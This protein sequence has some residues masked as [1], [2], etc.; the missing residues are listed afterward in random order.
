M[1]LIA[2]WSPS[3]RRAGPWQQVRT[4]WANLIRRLELRSWQCAVQ[5]Q[6]AYLAQAVDA[7][8]LDRRMR[9]LDREERPRFIG[10]F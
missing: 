3:A 4:A 6:E 5:E 2:L 10:Y 1:A 8:D 9:D 7:E